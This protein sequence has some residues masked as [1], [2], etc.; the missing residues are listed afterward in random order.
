MKIR[1]YMDVPRYRSSGWGYYAT[2]NPGLVVQEGF[3]RV[4]FDVELPP[5]LHREFD[6]AAPTRFMGEVPSEKA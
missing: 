1:L 3:K 5:E 4:A 2:S 6:V